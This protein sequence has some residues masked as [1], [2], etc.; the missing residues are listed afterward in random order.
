MT[1]AIETSPPPTEDGLRLM[2]TLKALR[3]KRN[4]SFLIPA[5]DVRDAEGKWNAQRLGQRVHHYA[6]RCGIKVKVRKQRANGAQVE[7][8]KVWRIA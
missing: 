4:N 1:Y 7:G 6:T 2:E 8:L 5:A 3:L